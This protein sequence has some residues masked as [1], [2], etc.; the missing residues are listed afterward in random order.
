MISY[1]IRSFTIH[2]SVKGYSKFLQSIDQGIH[3]FVLKV[4]KEYSDRMVEQA[5]VGP[6]VTQEE[7]E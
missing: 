6:S 7:L 4:S 5:G 3:E 2:I 1:R